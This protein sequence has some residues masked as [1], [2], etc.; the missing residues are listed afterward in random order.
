[1]VVLVLGVLKAGVRPALPPIIV[2]GKIEN[3]DD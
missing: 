3:E 2:L 1:M